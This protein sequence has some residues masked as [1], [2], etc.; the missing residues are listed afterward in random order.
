MKKINRSKLSLKTETLRRLRA[1]ELGE[2]A[3]GLIAKTVICTITCPELCNV[4]DDCPV[5]T[6]GNCSQ[7][8]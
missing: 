5:V 3:G 8:C 6:E 1:H 7:W 2:A 4:T